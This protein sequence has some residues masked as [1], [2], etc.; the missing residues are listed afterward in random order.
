LCQVIKAVC[1]FRNKLNSLISTSFSLASLSKNNTPRFTLHVMRSGVHFSR[2]FCADVK[3]LLFM[4]SIALEVKGWL[5]LLATN[6][7]TWI[8]V[9]VFDHWECMEENRYY[10]YVFSYSFVVRLLI[11]N[12]IS[13]CLGSQCEN[14]VTDRMLIHLMTVCLL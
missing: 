7:Q 6:G 13:T 5:R 11:L 4:L 10:C 1:T 12:M 14:E 8:I 2:K 3:Y 9:I